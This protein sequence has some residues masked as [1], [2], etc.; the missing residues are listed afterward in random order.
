MTYQEQG[1]TRWIGV[2]SFFFDILLSPSGH[3]LPTSVGVV[4]IFFSKPRSS[5]DC[6]E[7]APAGGLGAFHYQ[8]GLGLGCKP[9]NG[10]FGFD[11]SLTRHPGYFTFSS[12]R[13]GVWGS[14]GVRLVQV[15]HFSLDSSSCPPMS[16]E[17]MNWPGFSRERMGRA[18]RGQG[19]GK[20][21]V[22][23]L[24]YHTYY[25]L[26]IH[27]RIYIYLKPR[28]SVY[29]ITHHPTRTERSFSGRKR[30]TR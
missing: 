2:S 26:P 15:P 10:D 6:H 4:S 14:G 22:N 29:L 25:L 3:P 23:D 20:G 30:I 9:V 19:E 1:F 16:I 24:I 8:L 5:T 27:T 12:K 13:S 17:G 18:G 21:A 7:E 28:P 11:S